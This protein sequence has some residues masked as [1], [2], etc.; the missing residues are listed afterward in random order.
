M[1]KLNP[2]AISRRCNMILAETPF[3]CHYE[4]DRVDGQFRWTFYEISR[5]INR[6]TADADRAV[7]IAAKLSGE[8]IPER[9]S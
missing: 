3:Q 2:E 5:P 9:E 6:S 4:Y 1:L 8:R 7:A